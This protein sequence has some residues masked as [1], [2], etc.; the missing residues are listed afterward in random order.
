MIDHSREDLLFYDSKELLELDQ[1]GNNNLYDDLFE[2]NLDG[3]TKGGPIFRA[4]RFKPMHCSSWAQNSPQIFSSNK[5]QPVESSGTN[6][7]LV[8]DQFASALLELQRKL[9]HVNNQIS[10]LEVRMSNLETNN[11]QQSEVGVPDKDTVGGHLL[12]ACCW[13]AWP[14]L[15][16][17]VVA[18]FKPF[19]KLSTPG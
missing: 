4:K 9:S 1:L 15:L 2:L 19:S 16:H 17:L 12:S 14:V 13:L 7:I 18:K 10:A 5:V 3:P 6:S 8:K 11:R